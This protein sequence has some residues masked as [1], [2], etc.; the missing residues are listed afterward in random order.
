MP[1]QEYPAGNVS[2]EALPEV[3]DSPAEGTPASLP[4]GGFG[5]M[6]PKTE[7][8]PEVPE[9]AD[10]ASEPE[11]FVSAAAEPVIDATDDYPAPEFD[12][13]D[14]APLQDAVTEEAPESAAE[15][16]AGYVDYQEKVN[17]REALNMSLNHNAGLNLPAE[18]IIDDAAMFVD[19][20]NYGTYD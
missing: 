14:E 6:A 17:R 19:F 4:T 11:E 1:D 12:E 20:I 13:V 5:N 16:N 7:D 3:D 2:A 9:L 15:G 10:A 8:R 18:K